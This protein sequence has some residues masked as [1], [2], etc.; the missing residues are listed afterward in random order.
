S[1][2]DFR[3]FGDG[4]F[5]YEP[6]GTHSLPRPDDAPTLIIVCTWLGGATNKRIQRYTQGYHT[7]WPSSS[8]LL[9]KTDPTEYAF[10][11]ARSL[12]RKLR[13]AH[14]MIRRIVFASDNKNNANKNN[15]NDMPRSR[16]RNGT[17]G[18]ILLHMFSNGGASMA[19]QLL[20]SMN[21][22]LTTIGQTAPL[23]LRQVVLDSC[24]GEFGISKNYNAAAHSI[25]RGNPLRPLLCAVLYLVI[26]GIAGLE[27][28]GLRKHLA[29]TIREGLNSPGVV[30]TE[31]VRLYLASKGDTIVAA[32]DVRSHQQQALSRGFAG[33]MV[34]FGEA[35]HCSL[36]L[37][38]EDL[39]WD[40]IVSCWNQ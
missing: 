27:L 38:D 24:P 36:V 25:P 7:I 19:L 22:I 10:L 26:A 3:D 15:D 34:L 2:S 11:S 32:R 9:I 20:T 17:R 13:P 5:L 1:L 30:S 29:R 28:V 14:Q 33:D 18:G 16:T 39:Y 37:E 31:A 23:P 6:T 40:S 4:V 35:G 12:I 8:I 21:S